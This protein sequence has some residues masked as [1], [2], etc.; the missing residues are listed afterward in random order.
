MKSTPDSGS[1]AIP[2]SESANCVYCRRNHDIVI[3]SDADLLF[4]MHYTGHYIAEKGYHIRRRM[5]EAGLLL[6]TISGEG[7]LKYHNDF[8]QMTRGCCMLINTAELH[9]YYPKADGW[10]FKYIHFWGGMSGEY[11]GYIMSRAGPVT[12]LGEDDLLRMDGI[13]ER[14]MDLTG[15][16]VID[17]YPE[18]SSLIYSMLTMLYPGGGGIGDGGVSVGAAAMAKAL[19]FIRRSYAENISTE[20]I[21]GEVN[22]SRS[23]MSE[24]FLRTYGMPPHEYLVI[25]RLSIV[26]DMLT[27]TQM[28]VSDIAAC[29][30]FRDVF[31]LSRVFKRQTG[32]SPTEYRENSRG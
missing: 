11:I 22:L 13:L 28:T 20:D 23:Y 30:G 8:Y 26:K 12:V 21:A 9:E 24:L 27:N 4:H 3:G 14:V 16:D 6:L 15:A 19:R 32:I 5:G 25:Y 18:I 10:E 31:S 17:D 7:G 1:Y 2:L 29:T